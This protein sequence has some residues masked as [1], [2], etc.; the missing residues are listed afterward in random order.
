MQSSDGFYISGSLNV[1]SDDAPC[2]LEDCRPYLLV[3]NTSDERWMFTFLPVSFTQMRILQKKKNEKQKMSNRKRASSMPH[4]S[5]DKHTHKLLPSFVAVLDHGGK[6]FE[7]FKFT[8][9]PKTF[10]NR[11]PLQRSMS[12][13]SQLVHLRFFRNTISKTVLL[14]QMTPDYQTSP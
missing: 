10:N 13:W 6:K 1:K 3:E 7:N 9:V 2:I 5:Q 11:S 8:I 12:F 14:L 4:Y